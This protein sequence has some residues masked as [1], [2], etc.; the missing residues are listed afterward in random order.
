MSF[1]CGREDALIRLRERRLDLYRQFLDAISA[2]ASDPA[3]IAMG[4]HA[5]HL[6]RKV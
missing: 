2:T 6:G 1:A 5:I 4:A 3:V